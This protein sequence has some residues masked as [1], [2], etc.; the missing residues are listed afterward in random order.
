MT[1]EQTL[2]EMIAEREHTLTALVM[3]EE[4]AKAKKELEALYEAI[5]AIAESEA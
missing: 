3:P 1:S 4:K 2:N 5:E